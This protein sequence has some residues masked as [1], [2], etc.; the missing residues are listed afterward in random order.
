MK[1][2]IKG[3]FYKKTGKTFPSLNDLLREYG[4][5]PKAGS[6]M[7]LQYEMIVI[8][9]IRVQLRGKKAQHP[10]VIH[11]NFYEPAKGQKRDV[12]NVFTFA[13]KITED[14][15]VKCGVIPD[16]NPLFVKNTT[17]EFHFTNDVPFIEI[18]IEEIL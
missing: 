8:D 16:D 7:K 5:N 14:A 6:R 18:Y 1:L 17:H 12:M 4:K 13:D 3:D 2:I 15:L 11:Y 10:I 9:A